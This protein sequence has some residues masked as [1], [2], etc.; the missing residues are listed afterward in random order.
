M[1]YCSGSIFINHVHACLKNRPK[2]VSQ[3][4]YQKQNTLGSATINQCHPDISLKTECELRDTCL[5]KL[6]KGG[7][8]GGV[9]NDP[10]SIF[11]FPSDIQIS[12]IFTKTCMIKREEGW[13]SFNFF[14]QM[15]V[16]I[17]F[18]IILLLYIERKELNTNQLE[19]EDC[20]YCRKT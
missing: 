1:S 18:I 2:F 10:V 19:Y 11:S 14:L 7:G 8:G 12:R 16:F 20:D 6:L 9:V 4:I 5:Q 17:L 3:K 13:G 15:L